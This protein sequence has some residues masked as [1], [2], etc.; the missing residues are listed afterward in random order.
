MCSDLPFQ[1]PLII[2]LFHFV[3]DYAEIAF[4]VGAP[5]VHF[6]DERRSVILLKPCPLSP[7][8][9]DVLTAVALYTAVT[10]Y[11]KQVV[12]RLWIDFEFHKCAFELGA[13]SLDPD[14]TRE[15][16]CKDLL[17]GKA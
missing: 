11:N 13:F 6:L 12:S 16:S 8:L 9:A 14:L 2:Y 10:E 1:T 15:C 17:S 3:V 5:Q 7:Q 4:M